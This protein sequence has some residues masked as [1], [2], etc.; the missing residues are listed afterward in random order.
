MVNAAQTDPSTEA[1]LAELTRGVVDLHR[2]EELLERLA[3][4]RTLR[5]KAGFDPTA[6]DLHLGHTV[7]LTLMRRFQELGHR[8]IFVIG[9]FTARIGDPTGKSATRP[10]LDDAT[11]RTNAKTFEAQVGKVL[12]PELT[13]IRFN[14]EWLEPLGAAGLIRLASRYTVARML[15]RDDFK[16]RFRAQVPISIHEFLY[17]LLQGYDSVAL[18]AD[19][20]LGGSDQ[21]FNLLVG[22]ELMRDHG[23]TPQVVMTLPLLEGTD[24][25]IVDGTLVGEKMSKSLGNTVGIDEPPEEI[26]GKLMSISDDLMW[27]YYELL[28][29]LDDK[30]LVELKHSVASGTTHP[31]AAK[32]RLAREITARYHGDAAAEA[33]AAHFDQVHT[34]KEVPDEIPERAYTFPEGALP[35][36]TLLADLGLA[37]SRSEARRLIKGGGVR[38]NGE[39]AVDP[40]AQIQ[41]GEWLLQ[42]GKRKFMKVR[43]A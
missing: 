8:A 10:A 7:V 42:V 23:Q 1:K 28:S 31:K 37:S 38:L 14:S 39:R 13:E 20:E 24:A 16:K 5:I 33:A 34:R 36:A 2:R 29:T 4:G 32:A 25:R 19:V 43:P 40:Q 27:R 12:D 35:L 9:D 22:R 11:I 21:L 41:A 26:Y 18:E 6:P 30:A 3:S 17:P 15:E